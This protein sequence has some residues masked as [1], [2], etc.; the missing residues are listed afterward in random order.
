MSRR[1]L[2]VFALLFAV[3]LA[4][5][6]FLGI[7][8]GG[9]SP[10]VLP[11][12]CSQEYVLVQGRVYE[13]ESNS[14]YTNLYIRQVILIQNSE[15]IPIEQIKINIKN[16]QVPAGVCTGAVISVKGSLEQIPLPTNPGQFQERSYY[17]ARKVK[18][19]LEGEKLSLL[20]KGEHSPE[21]VREKVKTVFKNT[22]LKLAPRETGGIFCAMVLGE[23]KE[24]GKENRLLFSWSGMSHLLAVSG[25]H[26]AFF[27]WGLFKLLRKMRAPVVVSALLSVVFVIEYG[28]L[29]GSSASAIRAVVMF[30]LSLG[31][32]AVGRTYDLLSALALAAVLL[33][34]ENPA[35]LYDSGFLLSFFCIL[36]LAVIYPAMGNLG[37]RKLGRGLAGGLALQAAT[38]P[39]QMYFFCEVPVF[40]LLVNLF[41][42]PTAGIVLI[43]G[44]AGSLAGIICPFLG[45]VFLLPGGLL[46]EVYLKTG[47]IISRIPYFTLITGC[48]AWWK[49]V[50]Y[51]ALLGIWLIWRKKKKEK[52]AGVLLLLPVIL[53][54]FLHVPDNSLHAAFLDVGQGDCAVIRYQKSTYIVDGGS[55]SVSGSGNYRILPYLKW[56]GIQQVDG[57]FLSHM[58]ED[59]INGVTELLTAVA[60]HQT[61]LRIKRLF[62][63]E[64]EDKRDVLKQVE[65]AGTKA[66]CEVIYMKQGDVIQNGPLSLECLYPADGK[67]GESNENS[68]VLYLSFEEFSALFTGDMEGVGE[69]EVTALLEKKKITADILKVPHHGSKNSTSETFLDVLRPKAGI[70]SCGEDNRY[71]H[72]HRELLQRLEEKEVQILD[73]PSCGAVFVES[74]GK[75]TE[76]T[77][78]R[79]K[80]MLN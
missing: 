62:L 46:L 54:L 37:K 17:Y 27:G 68:Q 21:A 35:Y 48:P 52:K 22:L 41:V 75:T 51:Y 70:I 19:Y 26:V 33:L 55:S 31:A 8:L 29:T 12:G 10:P 77:F 23:K 73:T 20:E 76:L 49:I 39:V 24:A 2:C 13:T 50:A 60:E 78:Q 69:E 15:F 16:S 38:L 80:S 45:K 56:S 34:L 71:G 7:P 63:S 25:L 72:P 43:S 18:W 44:A 4:V 11:E 5:M 65:E 59:H 32:M 3:F 30:A 36:G 67:G 79:R 57:I 9:K 1:P 42:L 61:S 14:F 64:C 28:I 40:G 66:G 53:L 58:D 6:D 47:E 74:D